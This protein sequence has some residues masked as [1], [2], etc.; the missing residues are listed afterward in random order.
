MTDELV[1][2]EVNRGIATITLDS[3]H[4]RNALSKQLMRELRDHLATAT[5]TAEVR[6][7]VLTHT[8]P[9]FCSGMDLK[10]AAASAG[11]IDDQGVNA[12][13]EL[14]ENIWTCDKPVVAR[15]AGPA[16]AGGMGIVA[17]CDISIAVDSASFALTEVR[18]GL[19]P[20]IISVTLL[21]RLLPRAAHELFLTG[22]TFDAA[23]AK[24]VG[25]LNSVVPADQLDAEVTRYTDMLA[26]GSPVALAATKEMLTRERSTNLKAE[27]AEMQAL[28]A[29]LFAGPEAQEGFASFIQKRP[30]SWVPQD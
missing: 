30:A 24:D 1:H 29:K 8:G 22:E 25:L 23:R 16:R 27:F 17:A 21:P 9:V 14:L 12:F 20:A 19:A 2:Y 4:N 28:S 15:L 6:A 10:E 3:P 18:I 11:N 13:P 7:I 26:K 5:G